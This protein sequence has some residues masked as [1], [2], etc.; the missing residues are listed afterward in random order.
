MYSAL[1]PGRSL[2]GDAPDKGLHIAST[3]KNGN[4]ATKAI[5]QP[6]VKNKFSTNGIPDV[7]TVERVIFTPNQMKY[8]PKEIHVS[9]IEQ[10]LADGY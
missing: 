8:K 10:R 7:Q 5:Y 4:T 1:R 2:R 6:E 9:S 3:D